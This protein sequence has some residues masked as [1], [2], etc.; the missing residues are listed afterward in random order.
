MAVSPMILTNTRF[1][2][3][4]AERSVEP[5]RRPFV[6]AITTSGP[7]TR[8]SQPDAIRFRCALAKLAGGKLD[9]LWYTA[10]VPL[11]VEVLEAIGR[12]LSNHS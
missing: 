7:M 5:S 6:T 9:R 8:T 3:G 1:R 12:A 10:F 4:S 11:P 2:E